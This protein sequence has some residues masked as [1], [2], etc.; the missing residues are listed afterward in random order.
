VGFLSDEEEDEGAEG[1]PR[2]MGAMSGMLGTGSWVVVFFC[3][4]MAVEGG[5]GEWEG[6][7]S[8]RRV[9]DCVRVA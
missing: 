5:G 8:F 2:R 4:P 6:R 1:R 7:C 9:S 3:R